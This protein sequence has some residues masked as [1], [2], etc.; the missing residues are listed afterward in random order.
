MM[1][2]R[3]EDRYNNAEELLADLEAVRDGQTPMRARTRFDVS[4]LE[5][6]EQGEDISQQQNVYEQQAITKYRTALVILG[7]V[8]AVLGL[9][10]VLLAFRS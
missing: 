2:K 3:K 10:I 8:V 1:A 6:L 9:I 5:Q 4:A 7:A